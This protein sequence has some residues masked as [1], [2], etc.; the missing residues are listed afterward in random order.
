VL[1]V[2]AGVACAPATLTVVG[3]ALT[4]ACAI[5]GAAAG[6][7]FG[8]GVSTAILRAFNPRFGF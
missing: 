1:G 8:G 7:A 2:A 6:E 3:A 5:G 4:A